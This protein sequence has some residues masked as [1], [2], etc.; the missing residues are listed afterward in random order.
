VVPAVRLGRQLRVDPERLEHWVSQGG[1]ALDEEGEEQTG[2]RF[3]ARG[4]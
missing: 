1:R 2:T 4:G 3:P